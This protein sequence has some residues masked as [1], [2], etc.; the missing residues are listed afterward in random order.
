MS[1][2]LKSAAAVVRNVGPISAATAS[3]IARSFDSRIDGFLRGDSRGHL[4]LGG[5]A[6]PSVRHPHARP[7]ETN[8]GRRRLN[9]GWLLNR[10]ARSRTSR[11]D[12]DRP[13]RIFAKSVAP[14]NDL[15]IAA[16]SQP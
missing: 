11:V 10:A 12:R 13:S 2:V 7:E 8:E 14:G 5:T 16:L 15:V 9:R 1:P 6:R 4:V 3:T